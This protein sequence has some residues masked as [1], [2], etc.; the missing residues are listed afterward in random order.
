MQ[1]SPDGN[2]R[3]M[4]FIPSKGRRANQGYNDVKTYIGDILVLSKDVLSNKI[5]HL[6]V[7]FSR[8][9]AA[10]LKVNVSKC[11]FGLK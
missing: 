6:R 1:S 4:R 11:C 5:D 7:I 8:M 10:G 9:R 2:V 3:F